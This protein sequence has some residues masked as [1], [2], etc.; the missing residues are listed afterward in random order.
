MMIISEDP[1]IIEEGMKYKDSNIKTSAGVIDV[2][3]IDKDGHS[4]VVEIETVANDFAVG[5]VCR[6]TAGY[7][8]DNNI[9]IKNIRKVIISRYIKGRVLDGAEGANVEIY[10]IICTKCK[11]FK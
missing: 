1:A 2:L 6:L 4:I 11:S 8:R 3:L 10:K 7:A 9:D 5:Q